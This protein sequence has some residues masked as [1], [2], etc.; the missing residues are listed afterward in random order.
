M[1]GELMHK[2]GYS[3]IEQKPILLSAPWKNSYLLSCTIAVD[4]YRIRVFFIFLDL[5]SIQKLSV[6]SSE[7]APSS[8][9]QQL[10][11]I[12]HKAGDMLS[13]MCVGTEMS[14][15]IRIFQRRSDNR[16]F[17]LVPRWF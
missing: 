12:N 11:E 14:V 5:F 6:I 9:P 2:R 1:L 8:R 4:Q 17:S 3:E 16:Q 13:H 7:P 15:G 10:S